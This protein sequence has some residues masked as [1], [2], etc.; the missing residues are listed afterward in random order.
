[1][2]VRRI[3]SI[4]LPS[5]SRAGPRPTPSLA[6]ACFR[7]IRVHVHLGGMRAPDDLARPGRFVRRAM[8]TSRNLS[9]LS[10]NSYFRTLSLGTPMLYKPA[11][12]AP[13][14]P[15]T[16]APS[17]APT[18]QATSGPATSTGPMPGMAKNAAPNNIPQMPPQKAPA[19]PSVL[20]GR[21]RIES[22]DVLFRVDSLATIDSFFISN[23][24]FAVP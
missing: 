15:T 13:T 22:H 8:T 5:N 4:L 9:V 23:P 19:C 18:I 20:C 17:S 10:A 16:T 1:M 14:P 24:D 11:P 2:T 7:R 3:V 6:A 12:M 21:P